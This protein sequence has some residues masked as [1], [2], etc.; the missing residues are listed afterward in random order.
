MARLFLIASLLV[1]C[2]CAEEGLTERARVPALERPT[3]PRPRA[4]Q[5]SHAV[6]ELEARPA[7]TRVTLRPDRVNLSNEALI[8]T[9]PAAALER[10][11]EVAEPSHPAWPRLE[12]QLDSPEPSDVLEALE[13]ARRVERSATGA[14]GGAA[15]V[16]LRVASDVSFG[17]LSHVLL[18]AG[19]AGYASPRLLLEGHDE[20]LVTLEWGHGQPSAG[21]PSLDEIRAAMDAIVR[22]DEPRLPAG[23]RTARA[24]YVHCS[25][26]G[27]DALEVRVRVGPGLTLGT[28]DTETPASLA[29]CV[30]SLD[31][32]SVTLEVEEDVPFGELSPYWQHVSQASETLALRSVP[33]SPTPAD[34]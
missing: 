15:V 5:W 9:W 20:E 25:V 34:N 13:T 10:A 7:A 24:A 23:A 32:A 2:T 3:P 14:G 22:G 21:V 27:D 19:Q 12:I 4:E 6:V 16:D 8:R 17:A 26:A 18:S 29:S 11:G 31:A 30:R 28:C 33:P 1:G